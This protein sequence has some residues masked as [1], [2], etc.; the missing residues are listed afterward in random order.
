MVNAYAL[1]LNYFAIIHIYC[2]TK[3]AL[4]GNFIQGLALIHCGYISFALADQLSLTHWGLAT[5]YWISFLQVMASLPNDTKSLPEPKLIHCMLGFKEIYYTSG[6][7]LE[8]IYIYTYIYI[9]TIVQLWL[10]KPA[11]CIEAPAVASLGS[12][13]LTVMVTTTWLCVHLPYSKLIATMH[14]WFKSLS[15]L[16][17]NMQLVTMMPA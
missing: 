13:Y 17:D 16:S 15:R 8:I 5:P 9:Y 10:H 7:Y 11:I 1:A 6:N 2:L 4:G 14:N 3:Y 12:A